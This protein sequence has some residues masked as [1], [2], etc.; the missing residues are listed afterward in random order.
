MRFGSDGFDSIFRFDEIVEQNGI[1]HST[2]WGDVVVV[3]IVVVP[4]GYFVVHGFMV[5][6]NAVMPWKWIRISS[7][8][9]GVRKL[10][11]TRNHAISSVI[12]IISITQCFER[13]S[14]GFWAKVSIELT[15]WIS[16]FYIK[17][18]LLGNGGMVNHPFEFVANIGLVSQGKA[19]HAI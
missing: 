4:F 17:F 6:P 16:A 9:A 14:V 12:Q 13:F 18:F 8:I 10:R 11:Y 3:A 2:P 19:T 1:T 5:H 15:E 7:Y